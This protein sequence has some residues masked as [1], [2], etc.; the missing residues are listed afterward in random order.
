MKISAY[1]F[2]AFDFDPWEG[3][4]D[5]LNITE[6]GGF[7]L[8]LTNS[9]NSNIVTIKDDGNLLK[10]IWSSEID[11]GTILIINSKTDLTIDEIYNMIED[12]LDSL[13]FA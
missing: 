6:N 5:D 12:D 1:D 10:I 11:N 9:N 8:K 3:N 7:N 4:V 2:L 13:G